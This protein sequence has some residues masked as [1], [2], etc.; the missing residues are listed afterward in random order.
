[1]NGV[2]GEADQ[3]RERAGRHHSSRGENGRV[4]IIAR[5]LLI[6][7]EKIPPV[8]LRQCQLQHG[9]HRSHSH[10]GLNPVRLQDLVLPDVD[11]GDGALLGVVG[12]RKM[13]PVRA[14]SEAD[15]ARG[16]HADGAGA[17]A[18]PHVPEAD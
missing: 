4:A 7:E 6:D 14:P 13:V 18:R 10:L 9:P 8:E 2:A 12:D 11:K 5:G 1:M 17:L 15:A 3:G 16:R